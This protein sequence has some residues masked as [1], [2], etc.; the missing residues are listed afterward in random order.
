MGRSR[1]LKRLTPHGSFD[2]SRFR[3]NIIIAFVLVTL[4]H[5]ILGNIVL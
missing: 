2:G 1:K 3:R 4:I 5:V